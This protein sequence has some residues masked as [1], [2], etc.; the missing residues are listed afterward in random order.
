MP[1]TFRTKWSCFFCISGPRSAL[2]DF[3]CGNVISFADNLGRR[4]NTIWNGERWGSKWSGLI[5]TANCI[6]VSKSAHVGWY[7]RADLILSSVVSVLCCTSHNPLAWGW[8]GVVFMCSM[9]R[10]LHTVDTTPRNSLP[11]SDRTNWGIPWKWNHDLHRATRISDGNFEEMGIKCTHREKWS[12]TVKTYFSPD[13][14]T[15]PGA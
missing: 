9:P 11:L 13:S 15:S 7:G 8:Y 6:S 10:S 3:L 5:L 14:R 4:P 1:C 12:T 2:T